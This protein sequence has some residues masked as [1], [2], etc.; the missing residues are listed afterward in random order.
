[1]YLYVYPCFPIH[2]GGIFVCLNIRITARE[3]VVSS[4]DVLLHFRIVAE[5]HLFVN[6]VISLFNI[7]YLIFRIYKSLTGTF[8]P[9]HILRT[10]PCF[11]SQIGLFFA[12]S[13]PSPFKNICFFQA[14]QPGPCV[15][16][17][18]TWLNHHRPDTFPKR[19]SPFHISVSFTGIIW[20]S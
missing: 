5:I 2:T 9:S 12:L 13:R 10:F 11:C 17:T 16:L 3:H 7:R 14:V 15:F 6:R 19:A 8:I 20:F 1:M 4:A 18:Q